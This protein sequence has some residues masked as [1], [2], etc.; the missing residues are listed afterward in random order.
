MLRGLH[1]SVN[2]VFF[3]S[4]SLPPKKKKLYLETA[5][6]KAHQLQA[7]GEG[8]SRCESQLWSK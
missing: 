6:Q 3:L 4:L 1:V 8:K 2:M 5:W 7:G